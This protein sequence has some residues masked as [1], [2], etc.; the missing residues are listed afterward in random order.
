M[1]GIL[2]LSKKHCDES[3]GAI[4]EFEKVL[5]VPNNRISWGSSDWDP[6]GII[7]ITEVHIIPSSSETRGPTLPR[8]YCHTTHT[9]AAI[10]PN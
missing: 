6:L 2:C 3:Q 7:L 10:K 9:S 1:V 8:H 5:G 4:I